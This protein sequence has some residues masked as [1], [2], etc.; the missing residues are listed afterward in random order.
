[1]TNHYHYDK[2]IQ[3][4]DHNFQSEDNKIAKMNNQRSLKMTFQEML[5]NQRNKNN[6]KNNTLKNNSIKGNLK[7]IL[8]SK[9]NKCD[10]VD[11]L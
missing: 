4:A 2:V 5:E 7:N 10:D 6:I 9:I 3:N 8:T 1:M 11:K